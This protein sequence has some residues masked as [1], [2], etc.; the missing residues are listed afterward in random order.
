MPSSG[1][2]SLE[3]EAT[4]LCDA[5]CKVGVM[6]ILPHLVDGGLTVFIC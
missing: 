1:S 6:I 3:A 5:L 2:L 4:D